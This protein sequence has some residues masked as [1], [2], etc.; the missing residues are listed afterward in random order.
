MTRGIYD[1]NLLNFLHELTKIDRF[2]SYKDLSKAIVLENGKKVSPKTIERW[3]NFLKKEYNHP[4]SKTKE[5]FNFYPAFFHEKLGLISVC[6]I[7]EKPNLKLLGRL[8]FQDY[9]IWLFDPKI[10][11]SVLLIGY[12]VPI[13]Y[14]ERFKREW[15][16]MK[17]QGLVKNYKFYITYKGFTIYSPWH[18]VIDKDGIFHPENNSE[19]EIDRQIRRF[20]YYLNDLPKIEIMNPIKKNPLIVPVL[21]EHQYQYWTSP[22][23]WQRMKDKLG[24]KIYDYVSRSKVTSD[25]VGIKKVQQTL[26]EIYHKDII[27]QMRIVY[28]P[29]ELKNNFFIYLIVNF[30]KREVVEQIKML[31]LNSI[32]LRILPMS[33][34]KVFLISLTNSKCLEKI[35][36]ILRNLKIEKI[37]FLQH[38]K[39]LPLLTTQKYKKHDYFNHFNPKTSQ[40]NW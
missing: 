37:Y 34:N 8:P 31:A 36:E 5:K 39:S 6:I 27:L 15:K 40:W 30:E 29:I 28:M 13:I 2:M 18:K 11:E 12:L 16:K 14:L 4:K 38:E 20:R 1:Y 26:K 25:A 24:K 19:E 35:F 33:K 23:I 21:F 10:N 32:Y 9:V 17:R 22:K 3:F 7:S